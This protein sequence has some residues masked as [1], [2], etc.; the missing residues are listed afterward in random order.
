MGSFITLDDHKLLNGELR[1]REASG[2]KIAFLELGKSSGVKVGLELFQYICEFCD[3]AKVSPSRIWL[4]SEEMKP[5]Q[6]CEK[7]STY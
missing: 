6:G 4:R 1:A 3:R 2:G 5:E 7:K